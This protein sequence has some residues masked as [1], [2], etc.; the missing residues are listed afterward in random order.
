MLDSLMGMLYL[1]PLPGGRRGAGLLLTRVLVGAAFL[2]HGY[3]KVADLAGF[4]AE[5][6]MPMAAAVFAAYAQL[7]AGGLLILG[8]A[9]PLAALTIT[10]TMTVATLSLIA[11]GEPW[12][13]PHGHS[14]EA[15]FFYLVTSLCIALLGPGAYSLDSA[16][17][18]TAARD[19]A[20][21]EQH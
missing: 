18:S 12:I 20:T 17:V 10:G 3:G 5:F 13:N 1:Q 11:R 4:A 2:V 9:T 16:W 6:H 8:L 7:I 19:L 21:S 14:F 15:S